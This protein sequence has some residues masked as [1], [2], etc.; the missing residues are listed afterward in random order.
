LRVI[1]FFALALSHA[2][3]VIA[4]WRLVQRTD[5]DADPA[6]AGED[7]PAPGGTAS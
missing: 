7:E 6:L 2:L 5:L 4:G 1:D 3:L